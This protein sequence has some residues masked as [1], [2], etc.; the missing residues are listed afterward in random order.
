MRLMPTPPKKPSAFDTFSVHNRLIQAARAE[1]FDKFVDLGDVMEGGE[2]LPMEAGEP[3]TRIGAILS[4]LRRTRPARAR[5]RRAQEVEKSKETG[6]KPLQ[7]MDDRLRDEAH[8][9]VLAARAALESA[10]AAYKTLAE[11][12]KRDESLLEDARVDVRSARMELEKAGKAF[13]QHADNVKKEAYPLK[14]AEQPEEIAARA[15]RGMLIGLDQLAQHT[16]LFETSEDI[17]TVR[18]WEALLSDIAIDLKEV[19]F[20]DPQIAQ[21]LFG[22]D[23]PETVDAVKK[24][25]LRRRQR[26]ET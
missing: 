16:R 11:G 6:K 8:R 18:E 22:D 20:T 4:A 26:A 1:G 10:E 3:G 19:G 5:A 24:R 17:S 15:I 7:V 13:Q 23:A 2:Q 25:R 12:P 21:I 9:A 14:M